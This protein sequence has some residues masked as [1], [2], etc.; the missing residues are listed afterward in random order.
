MP[1]FSILAVDDDAD[2]LQALSGFLSDEGYTVFM[3]A[4]GQ[5]GISKAEQLDIDAVMLDLMLPDMNGLDALPKMKSRKPDLPVIVI[6]GAGTIDLAVKATKL[7][8]YDF[9]EKP[10]EPER[11]L[12]ALQHALQWRKLEQENVQLR[13]QLG[14]RYRIIGESPAIE[15]VLRLVRKVA[16]TEA[17]VLIRGES[18]V[19]KE[20]VARAVH[21]L[22]A[23]REGPFV[24][25]N[26]AAIPKDLVESELFGHEKGAFTGAAS[27]RKGKLELA[28]GGSLF[29]DEIG[30]MPSEAQAK[31]LRALEEGEFERVGGMQT[32][33]AD[34]R[35]VA[36]TNKDIEAEVKTGNFR[37]DLY[38]RLNVVSVFT[39]PLR[40]RR[41]DIPA[42]SEH[43]CKAF[44]RANGKRAKMISEQALHALQRHDWPGN[45]RELKNTIERLVIVGEEDTISAEEVASALLGPPSSLIRSW[46]KSLGETVEDYERSIVKMELE[47]NGWNISQA[48]SKLKVDRSNLQKKIKAWRLKGGSL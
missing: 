9:I 5:E 30:D 37:E 13:Q 6:S 14:E 44:C 8:A 47:A 15:E 35:I 7:G 33:K 19:G 34:V 18:G 31:V 1:N 46:G 27:L 12:L 16:P 11:V 41:G 17:T 20:L 45:V 4:T 48:A 40:D 2:I 42:L 25:V 28:D 23:R 39:P 26:C 24:Q 43:F 22:S 3:A 38:Y 10:L 21:A 32:M 36:A 29:L